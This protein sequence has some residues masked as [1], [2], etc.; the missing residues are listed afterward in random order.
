MTKASRRR[1]APVLPQ[2]V[3]DDSDRG[4]TGLAMLARPCRVETSATG[5]TAIGREQ[6]AR[7]RYGD[8]HLVDRLHYAAQI[9]DRQHE[10][11]TKLLEMW[12]AAGVQPATVA[13]YGER[14][15][16][17]EAPSECDGEPT[18]ADVYRR[19]VRPFRSKPPLTAHKL[20][21]VETILLG[22][23]PGIAWLATA[24]EAFSDLA[25]LW[26]MGGN[27]RQDS[28]P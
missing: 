28:T 10:A 12:T 8:A 5:S 17:R 18:A 14:S 6:A 23:H 26:K 21:I 9:S 15:G 7:I 24:Q 11:A 22:R 1:C 2:F 4:A 16:L 13:S 19:F 27:Q 3:A 25:D 20:E